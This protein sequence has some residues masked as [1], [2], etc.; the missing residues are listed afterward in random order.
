MAVGSVSMTL[1]VMTAQRKFGFC[2]GGKK[3]KLKQKREGTCIKKERAYAKGKAR[4]GLRTG[5]GAQ[6]DSDGNIFL[7]R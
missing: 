7:V 3:C 6:I 1:S 5:H 4:V 2:K